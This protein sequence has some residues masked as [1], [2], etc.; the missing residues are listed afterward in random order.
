MFLNLLHCLSTTQEPKLLD[1]TPR[2]GPLAGGTRLTIRGEFLDAGSV[3]NVKVNST[4]N[5]NIVKWVRSFITVQKHLS[6]HLFLELYY[7]LFMTFQAIQWCHQ[8]RDAT[9]GV[10][11]PGE[12]IGV[13]GLRRRAVLQWFTKFHILLWEKPYN[14]LHKTQQKLP[15]VRHLSTKESSK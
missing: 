3:I 1:F 15:Q 6:P 5:C 7:T 9:G 12:C 11:C 10:L 2:Q 13:C 4:Q 14:Q 8:V